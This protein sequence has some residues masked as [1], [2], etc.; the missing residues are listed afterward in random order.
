MFGVPA[1]LILTS[2]L[3]LVGAPDDLVTELRRREREWG[4]GEVIIAGQYTLE[5]LERFGR[6]VL[7]QLAHA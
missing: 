3:F 7:P 5:T 2:P 1:E 4:L 6:E